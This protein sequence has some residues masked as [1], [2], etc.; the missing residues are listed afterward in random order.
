MQKSA[1]CGVAGDVLESGLK[2]AALAAV[3]VLLAACG[4]TQEGEKVPVL[5]LQ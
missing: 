5:R 4:E 3:V 2:A 1:Q